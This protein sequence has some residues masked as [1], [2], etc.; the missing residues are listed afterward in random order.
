MSLIPQ[1]NKPADL[2]ITQIK[3]PQQADLVMEWLDT[4][5]HDIESQLKRNQSTKVRDATWSDKTK[6]ALHK[7]SQTKI[8]V[9]QQKIAMLNGAPNFNDAFAE[10]AHQLFAQRDLQDI[11]REIEKKYP[12]LARLVLTPPK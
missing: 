12:G 2:D 8:L 3:T 1:S 5:I 4:V 6:M 7:T 11:Y 9:M 10:V